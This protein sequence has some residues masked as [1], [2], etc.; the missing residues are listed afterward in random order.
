VKSPAELNTESAPPLDRQETQLPED[1]S[2]ARDWRFSVFFAAV[3]V[4]LIIG[5]VLLSIRSR[6]SENGAL[7]SFSTSAVQ[8]RTI[9]V[10]GTTEAV[11]MRAILAP[12][13]A[14]EHF[15]TL[16]VTRLIAGGARVRQGDVLAEFDRQAAMREFIDKQAE[17]ENLAN[18]VL[19]E[20][21]KESAARAKR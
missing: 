21:A 1:R 18:Q 3:T 2:Q 12:L 13:L 6:E 7:Q 8:D 11:R 10:T 16:T 17:Y 19:Q 9:R 15:A 20:Q 14:G 5:A 4:V